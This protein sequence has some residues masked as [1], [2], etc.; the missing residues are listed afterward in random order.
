MVGQNNKLQQ[1]MEGDGYYPCHLT[2]QLFSEL[3]VV[4]VKITFSENFERHLNI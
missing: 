2:D 3:F 1:D 4:T